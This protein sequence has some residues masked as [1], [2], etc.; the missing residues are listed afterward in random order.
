MQKAIII[1]ILACFS[2]PV[3]AQGDENTPVVISQFLFKDFIVGVVK[4][5]SGERINTLLNYDT[6]TE[7]MVFARDTVKL[8]LMELETIDTVY[9]GGREFVPVKNVFYVKATNTPVALFIQ[10]KTTAFLTGKDIG[11]GIKTQVGAI[12]IT[13]QVW[14][15]NQTYHLK[16]PDD[17]T[18]TPHITYWVGK[19]GKFIQAGSLKKLLTAFPGKQD[20]IKEFVKANNIHFNNPAEMAR[21]IEFC[22]RYTT[23]Y[24]AIAPKRVAAGE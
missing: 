20:A 21:L 1:F 13:S 14:Q 15:S 16:L 18:F 4:K 22:N 5:K 9:L 2:L 19:N 6:Y 7:E 11:Y 8:S 10:Y 3:F 24:A 12:H 17:Y 23:A